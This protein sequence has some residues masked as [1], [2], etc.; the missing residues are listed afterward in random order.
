M[1]TPLF[2]TE[3][4]IVSL[5]NTNL[6]TNTADKNKYI[7]NFPSGI[8]LTNTM[9][10]LSTVNMFFSFFNI[11]SALGNNTFSIDHP[12]GAGT[13]TVNITIADGYYTTSTLNA[14]IQSELISNGLYLVNSSGQYVYYINLIDNVSRYCG[15]LSA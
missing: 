1:T 4:F 9:L 15:Y 6:D 7:Y 2:N 5:N 14:Y 11:T 8:N 12:E 3:S 10:A 13:T